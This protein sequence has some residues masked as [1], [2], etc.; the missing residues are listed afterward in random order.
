M[1]AKIFEI[2]L[3]TKIKKFIQIG[4]CIEYGKI[5]LL[6]KKIR[7]ITKNIFYYGKANLISTNF[8]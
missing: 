6:K 7:I 3:K 2:F 4:S 5:N 1:D 8:Y